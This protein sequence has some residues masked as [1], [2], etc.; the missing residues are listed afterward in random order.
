MKGIPLKI[1][2][3]EFILVKA[4]PLQAKVNTSSYIHEMKADKLCISHSPNVEG[5]KADESMIVSIA[6]E[7]RRIYV[8]GGLLL[9]VKTNDSIEREL[10]FQSGQPCQYLTVLHRPV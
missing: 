7:Q 6:S 3:G 10:T 4:C 9:Y 2:I 5:V 8:S 1:C